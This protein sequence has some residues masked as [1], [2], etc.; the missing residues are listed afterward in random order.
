MKSRTVCALELQN[1]IPVSSTGMTETGRSTTGKRAVRAL[2]LTLALSLCG[3]CERTTPTPNK[4]T[5][6][7][8]VVLP[9]SPPMKELETNSPPTEADQPLAKVFSALDGTWRG[10]FQI[11]TDSRG[12]QPGA[13]PKLDPAMFTTAFYKLSLEI[14][15]EQQYTSESPFFQRV[16]IKDTYTEK[17]GKTRVVESSGVNKVQDGKLWCLVTKPDEVVLHA[18][19]SP[20]KDI[21]EWQ[22]DLRSPLKVEYFYETVSAT[23]YSIIGYGYYGNDK[24]ELMPRTYFYA[25]YQKQ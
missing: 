19:T 12:Q 4:P 14:D 18:G 7:S 2:S 1:W 15:V 6:S 23:T 8:A 25:Q 5:E 9:T 13:K 10:K 16:K 3:A 24:P 11:Y 20:A 21:I 22:R 17:D